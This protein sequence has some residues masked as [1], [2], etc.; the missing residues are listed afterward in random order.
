MTRLCETSGN[1]V[2]LCEI[3]LHTLYFKVAQ[4]ITEIR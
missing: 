4:R 2:V 1:F 3:A